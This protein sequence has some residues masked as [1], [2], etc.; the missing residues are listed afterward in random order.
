MAY[1]VYELIDPRTDTPFYV[2][3]GK[4][5]RIDHHE[6]EAKRGNSSKKCALIREI[7][8]AGLSV[9]KAKLREFRD[10]DEAF[11]YEVARIA[12]IGSENLTNG[13]LGGRSPSWIVHRNSTLGDVNIIRIFARFKMRAN[14]YPPKSMFFRLYRD[15]VRDV[16]EVV[17]R[18]GIPWVNS[19]VHR[20][21]L[22]IENN[23]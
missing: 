12:E 19:M 23:G 4:R 17:R 16:R 2:G 21:G 13:T 11:E 8:D 18:R 7:W 3:K 15:H 9:R 10:E 6:A 22:L 5:N 14:D 20:T 1:Y